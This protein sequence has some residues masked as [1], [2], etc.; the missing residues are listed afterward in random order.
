MGIVLYFPNLQ[1]LKFILNQYNN[2]ITFSFRGNCDN[3]RPYWT[4]GLNCM[5]S[6]FD[7]LALA[8]IFLFQHPLVAFFE[9]RVKKLYFL[10]LSRNRLLKFIS[11][12]QS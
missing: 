12:Q 9:R 6:F 3:N 11:F 1:S 7:L 5:I 4:L 10:F 2:Q 8:P